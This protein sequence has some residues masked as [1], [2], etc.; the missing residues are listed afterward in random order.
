[1]PDCPQNWKYLWE[2]YSFLMVSFLDCEKPEKVEKL[3]IQHL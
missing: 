1:V 2:G 3:K